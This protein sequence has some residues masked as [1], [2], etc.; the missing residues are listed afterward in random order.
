MPARPRQRN[1]GESFMSLTVGWFATGALLGLS[2]GMAPG[3]LLALVIAETLRGS[4]RA[5][6]LAALAPLLT[7]LPIIA[8]SLLLVDAL[9]D[10]AWI[11]GLLSA[12][13]AIYLI[14]LGW[15]CLTC[16]PASGPTGRPLASLWRGVL[17][18][19][20]SPHPYL[21]WLLVGGPACI[22]ASASGI[23]APAAYLAGFYALL[24]GSKIGVA[25]LT[26]RFRGLLGGRGYRLCMS[27]LGLALWAMS[28]A[29]LYDAVRR[30]QLLS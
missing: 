15:E 16:R 4:V 29:L 28:A 9:R 30:F 24:L 7:D 17:V 10:N 20:L 26:V 23:A 21:F 25:L 1:P 3:P 27:L 19:A 14:W 5:G 2:A 6:I 12:A 18:N 11:P 22:R 8:A 13:G